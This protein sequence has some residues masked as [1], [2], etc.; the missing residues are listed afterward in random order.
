[1]IQASLRCEP[2]CMLA[3]KHCR[4]DNCPAHCGLCL[5]KDTEDESRVCGSRSTFDSWEGF[6]SKHDMELHAEQD[7][8][9]IFIRM[10]GDIPL[11]GPEMNEWNDVVGMR[12]LK[13]VT[14]RPRCSCHALIEETRPLEPALYFC[15]EVHTGRADED[16]SLLSLLEIEE[17]P[18]DEEVTALAGR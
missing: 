7:S 15:V 8:L 13:Y 16:M 17:E 11:N 1:M 18:R 6:M 4:S 5:L 14:L 2:L 3:A 9:D 10:L 12:R